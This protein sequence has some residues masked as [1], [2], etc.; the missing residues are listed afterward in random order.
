[1]FAS[2]VIWE[3]SLGVEPLYRIVMKHEPKDDE[4]PYVLESSSGRDRL[5]ARTWQYEGPGATAEGDELLDA[6][7]KQLTGAAEPERVAPSVLWQSREPTGSGML[8][9][10]ALTNDSCA[11]EVSNYVDALG[12]RSWSERPTMVGPY[13]AVLKGM[14]DLL[15]RR[16][17]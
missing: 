5:G 14:V 8:L 6:F 17:R 2:K 12:H 4:V 15:R 13:E 10:I 1:M 11:L 16:T 3:S 9:R 7:V